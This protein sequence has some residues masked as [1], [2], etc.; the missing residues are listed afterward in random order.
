M[1]ATRIYVVSRRSPQLGGPEANNRLVRAPT[2][3][4]ALR[5]VAENTLAVAVAT[6]DQLVELAAAGVKV[7]NA[8]QDSSPTPAAG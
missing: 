2:S 1:A 8:K 4:Q 6:Q 7:E 5:H 3:S